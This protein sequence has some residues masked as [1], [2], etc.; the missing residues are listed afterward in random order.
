MRVSGCGGGGRDEFVVVVADD[1]GFIDFFLELFAEDGLLGLQS[2]LPSFSISEM[3]DNID[4]EV[5]AEDGL[6]GMSNGVFVHQ[7]LD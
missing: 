3:A 4:F 7:K 2:S 1:F 5:G 6:Y